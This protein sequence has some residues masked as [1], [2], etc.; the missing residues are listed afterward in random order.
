MGGNLQPLC[1]PRE[2]EQRGPGSK[3][4]PIGTDGWLD[5]LGEEEEHP[6]PGAHKTR[7]SSNSPPHP[8]KGGHPRREER[9]LALRS[10]PILLYILGNL[11]T[12]K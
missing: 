10:A 1:H 6:N 11:S 12:G 2:K 7:V 3:R 5:F 9:T 8:P 4:A